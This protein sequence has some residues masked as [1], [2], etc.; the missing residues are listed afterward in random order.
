MRQCY[1]IG[2]WILSTNHFKWVTFSDRKHWTRA[3]SFSTNQMVTLLILPLVRYMYGIWIIIWFIV[4]YIYFISNRILIILI[5]D[6]WNHAFI[7]WANKPLFAVSGPT[8][9]SHNASDIQLPV[10][11]KIN[12][13]WQT[14]LGK[15]YG[16][17]RHIMVG[18]Q[19]GPH[20][21]SDDH[22]I[23]SGHS[24]GFR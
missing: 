22:T 8:K 21:I 13:S 23:F 15:G 11:S 4:Y 24:K 5:N 16:K 3:T 17:G 9:F 18:S 10:S 1:H 20:S 12:V 2:V 7:I 19:N 6:I 14:H